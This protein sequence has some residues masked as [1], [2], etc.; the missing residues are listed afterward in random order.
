[1]K[2]IVCD[3]CK[4]KFKRKLSQINYSINHYCSKT[5]HY[6]ARRLGIYTKC[7]NCNNLVYKKLKDVLLSKNKKFFC[8][9]KCSNKVIGQMYSRENHPNWKDGEFSYKEYMNKQDVEKKCVLCKK[10]NP[11]VL[12]VHHLDKNRRNNDLKNLI[13]LCYNCHFLV[14]H[15]KEE[16]DKM[17]KYA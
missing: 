4:K 14:H 6:E 3:I 10:E 7:A 17:L 8:S 9:K 15:Y 12:V 16:S 5:C 2:E 13:W 1:M 11:L